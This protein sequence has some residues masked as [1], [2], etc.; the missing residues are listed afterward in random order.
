ML[1]RIVCLTIDYMHG[2]VDLCIW[3]FNIPLIMV[4]DESCL[5]HIFQKRT[6]SF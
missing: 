1:T 6:I 2:I 3:S 5:K 4:L